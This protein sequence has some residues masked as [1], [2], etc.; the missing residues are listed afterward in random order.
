M[1]YIEG[2]RKGVEWEG[3]GVISPFVAQDQFDNV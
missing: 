1:G 2:G 3:G